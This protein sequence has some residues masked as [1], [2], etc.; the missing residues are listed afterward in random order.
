MSRL[1]R[2]LLGC[3]GSEFPGSSLSMNFLRSTS[4]TSPQGLPMIHSRG[5][6][7]MDY[8]A[9]GILEWA[10]E[11]VYLWSDAIDN[12]YWTKLNATI[13]A[14]QASTPFDGVVA[15]LIQDNATNGFH[16][17]YR[18]GVVTLNTWTTVYHCFKVPPTNAGRWCHLFAYTGGGLRYAY[19]DILNGVV[20][21]KDAAI[22]SSGIN[23]LGDGW[24]QCWVT[25]LSNNS[26]SADSGF[27]LASANGVNSYAG[28]GLGLYHCGAQFDR[29][30]TVR[31]Y[32]P[33]TSSG[34]FAPRFDYYPTQ[35]TWVGQ[36]LLLQ[37][38]SFNQSP[39]TISNASY[40]AAP[41]AAPDGTMTAAKIVEDTASNLHMFDQAKNGLG[42][43]VTYYVWAKAAER[44]FFGVY[45]NGRNQGLSFNLS[46][47]AL[48]NVINGAPA[49]TNIVTLGDGWYVCSI[50]I[51]DN[52]TTG[53]F[54]IFPM[55][56][57]TTFNY[58]GDGSSG[59]YV[60]RVM[61]QYGNFDPNFAYTQTTTSALQGTFNANPRGYLTERAATNLALQSSDMSNAAWITAGLGA[62]QPTRTRNSTDVLSPD[63]SNNSTKIVFPSVPNSGDYSLVYQQTTGLTGGQTYTDSIYLRGA[64]GG[65]VVYLM[66][67]FNGATYTKATCTLTT[68]WQRFSYGWSAGAGE[69]TNYIQIGVDR[70]DA[71]Q[72][73]QPAST[74]Y[75]YIPQREVR[76]G[77]SNSPSSPI[78]TTSA[79]VTRNADNAYFASGSWYNQS[80]GTFYAQ[81][82]SQEPGPPSAAVISVSDNTLTNRMNMYLNSNRQARF[83]GTTAGASIFNTSA[84][85]NAFTF[86]NTCKVAASY[87]SGAQNVVL[88]AGTAS[89]TTAA[90]TFPV[91]T[92]MDI[93]NLATVTTGFSGWFRAIA[94][95]PADKTVTDLQALTT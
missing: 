25:Y 67:T 61:A 19:F 26:G 81:V 58:L 27:G 12:A 8:N 30:R 3:F 21:N 16:S 64:V 1:R 23:S 50:T 13:T 95:Y 41:I 18:V 73:T 14:N 87:V 78:P 74:V 51:D 35:G 83:D 45:A 66:A 86:G 28:S 77:G 47:G 22:A 60:W 84:T 15:D 44:T 24:Y 75:A 54:R 43:R 2:R 39:W 38:Q 85:L 59:V 62:A 69:T 94:Y 53:S 40:S 10:P 7:A 80:A 90:V 89:G 91:I 72:A 56:N 93:G 70:R 33:T 17:C 36:N 55:V 68:E 71:T 79:T 42:R 88:N 34:Y 82:E 4:L 52:N 48:G 49:A 57:A 11:N 20:G 6:G 37:S 46:T 9:N 65:E 92:R 29:S 5:G 32:N 63:G 76:Q 31:P